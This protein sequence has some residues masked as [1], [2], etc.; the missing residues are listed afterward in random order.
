MKFTEQQ[1]PHSEL[2]KQIIASAYRVGSELK[3]GL[4]EK[5]YE[6]AL[7]IDFAEQNISYSQ[8]ERYPVYYHQKNCGIL[9]PD[10]IVDQ[11]VIADTKVVTEINNEHISKMQSYL[12]ISGLKI[13]LIINFKYT[14][15]SVRRVANT[16]TSSNPEEIKLK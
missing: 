14:S 7:C 10:L 9:I 4:V 12:K 1:Y 11:K 13:G 6:N 3:N 5:I 2:T 16:E 15:I 8:Q